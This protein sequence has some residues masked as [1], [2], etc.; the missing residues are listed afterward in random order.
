MSVHI[1]HLTTLIFC[2]A[3]NSAVFAGG[4]DDC[5]D[6]FPPF[7]MASLPHGHKQLA[8][9]LLPESLQATDPRLEVRY[10]M[11]GLHPMA[12]DFVRHYVDQNQVFLQLLCARN[13]ATL[14]TMEKILAS[15][16]L[17][18]E[19]KYLAIVESKLSRTVKSPMGAAGPWQLMPVTARAMGLRVSPGLDE[20]LDIRK[21]TQ[22]AAKIL[23]QLQQQYGDWLLA[24]AAFNAG[25]GRMSASL[26][27]GGPSDFWSIEHRLPRETQKHIRKFIA[28]HYCLEGRG[29]I[30][31][32]L[33][34]PSPLAAP[35][36]V[37]ETQRLG[38]T[39]IYH[40]LIVAGMLGV[41]IHLFE[42]LNPGF[43]HLARED[44]RYII[45]PQAALQAFLEKRQLMQA[46]SIRYLLDPGTYEMNRVA[47]DTVLPA[48]RLD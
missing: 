2:L 48:V 31:T 25:N 32:G 6:S 27:Q 38:I 33:L 43:N 8:E 19:L 10:E 21:S 41:D 30:T 34:L 9:Q 13:Q 24:I 22:A 44:D 20:Q 18:I 42:Q 14:R 12:A 17:P 28:T 11:A 40:S 47:T 16:K 5:Q 23:R 46:E 39:G 1:K 37:G 4:L 45:L 26:R 3:C 35:E 7:P 29:G 36:W 15:H